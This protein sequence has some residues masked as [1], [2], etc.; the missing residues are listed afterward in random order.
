MERYWQIEKVN[1]KYNAA[2]HLFVCILILGLA[3]LLIGVSNLEKQDSAKVLEM[4]TALIGIIML[5]PVFLPEQAK[6][7]RDLTSSKYMKSAQVYFI[8]FLG[9]SVILAVFLILFIAMMKHNRCE[10]PAVPYFFGTYTEMLFMGGLG[11]FFY[12]LCDNLII[13]YMIPVMY[14]IAAIGSGSK[15][16]KVFYPFSMVRGSYTEKW[17]LAAAGALLIAAGILLRCRR[18]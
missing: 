7:I 14:Y 2:F 4:Y 1:F 18:K 12:G 8:R 15:F 16:L 9:N 5:T 3:P 17:V 11:M 13:G 10:F 6:E